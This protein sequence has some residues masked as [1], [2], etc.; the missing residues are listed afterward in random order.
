M[1]GQKVLVLHVGSVMLPDSAADRAP[2]RELASGTLDS[3]LARSNT[4][5][6][7]VGLA[8]QRRA[9]RRNPTLAVN[10]DRIPLDMLADPTVDRVPASVILQMRGLAAVTGTR[11]AM[12]P[13]IVR[14]NASG[15]GFRATY[16]IAMVDTRTSTVM[17]RM[18]A[19][20]TGATPE[21]AL[22]AAAATVVATSNN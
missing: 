17:A 10:P 11:F 14:I 4:G 6:E 1:A 7:W 9:V 22:Q 2:V 19:T 16:V 3:A 20:G 15:S 21:A 13:A 12:A 18:R 5:V 8:A